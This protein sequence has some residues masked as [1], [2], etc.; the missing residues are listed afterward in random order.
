MPPKDFGG[1]TPMNNLHPMIGLA[2]S[3]LTNVQLSVV[4]ASRYEYTFTPR[5]K[6]IQ[7]RNVRGVPTKGKQVKQ[8]F[9]AA[10]PGGY[11]SY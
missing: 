8:M 10:F 11:A 4:L 5:N 1:H 3:G 6:Q 2:C 9:W 7:E